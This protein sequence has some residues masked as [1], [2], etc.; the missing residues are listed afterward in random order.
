MTIFINHIPGIYYTRFTHANYSISD[1][2]DL[3]VFLAGWA[4]RYVVG[5]PGRQP[6]PWYLVLRLGGRALTLY[7]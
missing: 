6:P 3:F 1:S 5:R 4:L 7:A 2:A